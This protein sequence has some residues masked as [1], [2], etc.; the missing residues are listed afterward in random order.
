MKVHCSQG[1]YSSVQLETTV[2]FYIQVPPTDLH[3]I[4]NQIYTTGIKRALKWHSEASYSTEMREDTRERAVKRIY[5][6]E[7]KTNKHTRACISMRFFICSL[8]HT[9]GDSISWI[10]LATGRTRGAQA[11]GTSHGVVKQAWVSVCYYRDGSWCCVVAKSM[12]EKDQASLPSIGRNMKRWALC[13]VAGVRMTLGRGRGIDGGDEQLY[14]CL[15][16]GLAS[17]KLSVI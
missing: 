9:K 3:G 5:A 16:W 15:E 17:T 14:Y 6:K 2:K 11:R 7:K 10:R 1:N 4:P 12:C 13:R 8:G